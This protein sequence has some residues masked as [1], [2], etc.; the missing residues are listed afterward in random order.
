[1]EP[2]SQP[3][4]VTDPAA[5]V[6]AEGAF[7]RQCREL[8]DKIKVIQTRDERAHLQQT[9]DDVGQHLRGH[10][11]AVTPSLA[12][13]QLM[14]AAGGLLQADD[15]EVL[16]RVEKL[17]NKIDSL[18]KRLMENP[19]KLRDGN[20]WAQCQ[21]D[22]TEM[23]RLLGTRLRAAWERFV[24]GEI[25]D[26]AGLQP[27]RQLVEG[28]PIFEELDRLGRVLRE[29]A[30]KLPDVESDIAAV[31]ECGRQM[32]EQ[33]ARLPGDVPPAVLVFLKQAAQGGGVS[34]DSLT[35]EILTCLRQ[36][37]FTKS[38]SVVSGAGGARATSR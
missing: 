3:P 38:L 2:S 29:S 12:T 22:A 32:D 33:I 10:I 20:L 15:L 19:G 36:R 9:F 4:T 5:D 7:R 26:T 23:T 11:A 30:G 34:L 6:M 14:V 35:D 8:R 27:F 31:R 24:N 1:M 13:L 25:R 18:Q 21:T 28:K 16:G 37:Q 17:S